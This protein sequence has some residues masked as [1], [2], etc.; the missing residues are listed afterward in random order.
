M[1]GPLGT[2]GPADGSA[3]ARGLALTLVGAGDAIAGELARIAVERGGIGLPERRVLAAL[4]RRGETTARAIAGDEGLHKTM[5]SRAVAALI[6]KGLVGRRINLD[7]LREALLS[8]TEKGR[9][10]DRQ[11][12]EAEQRLDARLTAGL[13]PDERA[14]FERKLGRLSAAIRTSAAPAPGGPRRR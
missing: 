11:I 13:T 6:V 12:A 3:A 5:V 8:P 14:D 4:V 1:P 7:D 9:L 2:A 10:V